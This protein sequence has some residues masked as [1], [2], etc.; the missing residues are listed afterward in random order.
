MSD[1]TNYVKRLIKKAWIIQA[2][3]G[4]NEQ[5]EIA[6]WLDGIDSSGKEPL[7]DDKN[8][9]K[10]E[11]RSDVVQFNKKIYC[12]DCFCYVKNIEDP[13]ER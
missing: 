6:D 13:E 7:V 2:N 10:C 11:K 3:L 12:C 4:E 5:K 8:S 9:C 1:R